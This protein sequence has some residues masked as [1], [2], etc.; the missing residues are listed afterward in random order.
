S[1]A[2]FTLGRIK[3]GPGEEGLLLD[4]K[5]SL[6]GN[7]LAYVLDYRAR[8]EA[9]PHEPTTQQ[10]FDEA[11]FEAYRALGYH[12]GGDL[13]RTELLGA[14]GTGKLTPGSWLAALAATLL[15]PG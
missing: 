11:Q 8:H 10:L 6:T 3:Y 5:S 14:H 15:G 4:V 9:F 1:L 7:E 12:V 13:F 2:H